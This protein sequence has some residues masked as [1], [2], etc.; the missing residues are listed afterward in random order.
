MERITQISVCN[1]RAFYNE[2][3]KENKYQIS[4]NKGENLLIYGENGSGKSSLFKALEDFFLSADMSVPIES[5]IYTEGVP[6]LPDSSVKIKFTDKSEYE[7]A[8]L[9]S[10]ALNQPLFKNITRAFLTYR[11]VLN[12]YFL[13]ISNKTDNPNLFNLFI[14]KLLKFLTDEVSNTEIGRQIEDIESSVKSFAKDFKQLTS[15]SSNQDR[16]DDIRSTLKTSIEDKIDVINNDLT[17]LVLPVLIKVNFYLEKYFNFKL[18][19]TLKSKGKYLILKEK[20]SGL[21]L[22]KNLY[23]GLKFNGKTLKGKVYQSFLNEAR[24]SALALTVYLAAL[25]ISSERVADQNIYFLF[26]DDIFIGLD[27]SNRLPLLAILEND[28]RNFQIFITTYDRQW[29]EVAK[30]WFAQSNLTFRNIELYSGSYLNGSKSFEIPIIIDPSLGY[31]EKAKLYY[32]KKDYPASANYLRKVCENEIKRILPKNLQMTENQASGELLT[33]TGLGQL[34]DKFKVYS[35]LNNLDF[36]AFA[37]FETYTK[38]I[39][40]SL[41]HDDLNAPHYK[42]EIEDGIRL[43]S[44]FQK[45]KSKLILSV[46]KPP[47]KVSLF[48]KGDASKTLHLYEITLLENLY[49]VSCDQSSPKLSVSNCSLKT[50]NSNIIITTVDEAIKTILH[51]RGYDYPSDYPVLCQNIKVN[52]RKKLSAIMV[53]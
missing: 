35:S 41:S 31:F 14:N 2:E 38:I 4:L 30:R 53:F 27:T 5:N 7:F 36:T 37:Q 11:D 26:L 48:T 10:T 6:G 24:L 18:N 28:F 51:E 20:K 1:Y 52:S 40:N 13:D 22:D 15:R 21:H 32:E 42:K 3:N 49:L 19:I 25:K 23:L 9:N 34:F 45:I 17:N 50:Q 43:V 29:F 39:L 47:L 44:E 33:I 12:T 16:K 46:D 8:R